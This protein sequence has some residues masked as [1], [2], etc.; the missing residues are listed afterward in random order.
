MTEWLKF[1]M[2]HFSGP[3]LQIWILGADLLHSSATPYT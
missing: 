3:G 2:V 1:R